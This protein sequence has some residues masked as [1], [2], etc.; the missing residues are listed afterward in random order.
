M[1][2]SQCSSRLLCRFTKHKDLYLKADPNYSGRYTVPVIWDK[3]HETI[4]SN[5][6]ADI[7]RMLAS[8]FDSLLPEKLREVNRPGGGLLPAKLKQDIE[9][10]NEWVYNDINNGVYKVMSSRYR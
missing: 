1:S 8:G 7:I 10:Q 5:E 6:S 3:K 9:E 2:I 4:V